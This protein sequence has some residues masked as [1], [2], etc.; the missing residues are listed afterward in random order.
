VNF[1]AEMFRIKQHTTIN[2]IQGIQK[3]VNGNYELL[4]NYHR[5][6]DIPPNVRHDVQCAKNNF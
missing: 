1:H 5:R 2:A 6:E 3:C 4:K